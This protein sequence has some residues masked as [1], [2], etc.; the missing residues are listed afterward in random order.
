M[1]KK[2]Y[3]RRSDNGKSLRK[4]ASTCGY[5]GKTRLGLKKKNAI[6]AGDIADRAIIPPQGRPLFVTWYFHL[7]PGKKKNK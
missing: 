6:I 1:K 4:S 5:K 2:H 3:G 7:F